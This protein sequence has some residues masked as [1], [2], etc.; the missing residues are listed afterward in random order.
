MKYSKT[1]NPSLKLDIIGVS[2]ISPEGLK[3]GMEL[4][5]G[6][7]SPINVGNS[8]PLSNKLQSATAYIW[9]LTENIS[10]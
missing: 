10:S 6:D 2:I 4:L 3:V 1:L 8:L 7:K 5:S 9:Q